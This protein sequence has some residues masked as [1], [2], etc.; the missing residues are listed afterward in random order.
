M[1]LA[2]M[3]TGYVGIV[4]GTG[5]ANLGNAVICVDVDSEKN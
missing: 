4:S 2:I 3:G 1:K 5:L